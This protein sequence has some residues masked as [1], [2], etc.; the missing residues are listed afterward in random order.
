MMGL[1]ITPVQEDEALIRLKVEGQ[2]AA[3][4]VGV[5]EE[6]CSPLL[7]NGKQVLLDLSG[8]T[9]VNTEGLHLLRR[10]AIRGAEFCNCTPLLSDRLAAYEPEAEDP[11]IS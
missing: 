11:T 8:V 6:T 9:F 5:L 2:I 7:S 1:W 4:G 10:L 3:D